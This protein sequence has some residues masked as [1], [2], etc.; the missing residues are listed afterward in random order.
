MLR[1]HVALREGFGD[2]AF[3]TRFLLCHEQERP[4]ELGSVRL[5]P[6]TALACHGFPSELGVR[7][8]HN[9]SWHP[10]SCQ[11]FSREADIREH[12]GQTA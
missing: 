10:R 5:V 12:G 1:D 4:G 8:V 9:P 11:E 7:P 3:N 2:P 6:T